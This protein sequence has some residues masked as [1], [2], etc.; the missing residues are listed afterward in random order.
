MIYKKI[1]IFFLL[2]CYLFSSQ[3]DTSLGK[4]SIII[5]NKN[6]SN[7]LKYQNIPSGKYKTN[8]DFNIPSY[9]NFDTEVKKY[10][11][12]WKEDGQFSKI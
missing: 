11:Y 1:T 2:C 7:L 12:M 3:F 6:K 5:N 8:F 4:C 10:C 9:A